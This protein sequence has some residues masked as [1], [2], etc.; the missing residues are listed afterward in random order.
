ML[1]FVGGAEEV[2]GECEWRRSWFS[3]G[4]GIMTRDPAT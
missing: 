4:T 1:L 3:L 2:E